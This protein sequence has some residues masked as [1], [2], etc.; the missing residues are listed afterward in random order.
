M[1][2]DVEVK[3]KEIKAPYIALGKEIDAFAD[4]ITK[5][6]VELEG[7]YKD[8][9]KDEEVI[10]D[11][12]KA[13][14]KAEKE[15]VNNEIKA[16]IQQIKDKPSEMAGCSIDMIEI[17]IDILNALPMNEDSFG[18]YLDQ[19][20]MAH[21]LSLMKLTNML[22]AAKEQ[23]EEKE[24]IKKERAEFDERQRLQ[25]EEDEK[26]KADQKKI[27][28]ENERVRLDQFE[29][30]KKI[31]E[32]QAKIDA[33]REEAEIKRKAE[34]ARALLLKANAVVAKKQAE[35]EVLDKKRKE[36]EAEEALAHK[37]ERRAQ[38]FKEINL[39]VMSESK[40]EFL[41]KQIENR[42]I[43]FVFVDW[44]NR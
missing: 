3:R 5:P 25:R 44:G 43:P 18:Q 33:D 12:I 27:D 16:H 4:K 2:L 15:R 10:R 7:R 11:K 6:I 39:Y 9:R 1:R 31:D 17:S 42:G 20:E 29:A 19:A 24:R 14:K 38:T 36:R 13:D 30:Q 26:R 28:D 32:A 40:T 41:L 34:A 23:E 35:Q 21:E 22:Q 8:A 37:A